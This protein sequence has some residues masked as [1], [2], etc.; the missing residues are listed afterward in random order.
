MEAAVSDGSK[1]KQRTYKRAAEIA[2]RYGD[3]DAALVAVPASE[4]L[5]RDDRPGVDCHVIV[6]ASFELHQP[7]GRRVRQD[8]R[9]E[10]RLECRSTFFQADGA[11]RPPRRCLE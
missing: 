4:P 10:T 5:A 6:V 9:A 3:H 11:D 2:V 7:P 8:P 1:T